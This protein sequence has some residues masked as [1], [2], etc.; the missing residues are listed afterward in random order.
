MSAIGLSLSL[1][2]LLAGMM[3]ADAGYGER[4][5]ATALPLRDVLLS[6][7]FVS[8][9]MLVDPGLFLDEPVTIPRDSCGAPPRE[10]RRDRRHGDADALPAARR[11]ACGREPRT[12]RRIRVRHP[13]PG[14]RPR[15]DQLRRGAAR[16]HRRRRVDGGL[17]C[18]DGAC[19]ATAGRRSRSAAARAA[20]ENAIHRRSSARRPLDARSCRAGGLRRGR[21]PAQPRSGGGPGPSH[22][23]GTQR[24]AREERACVGGAGLLRRRVEPGDS[25]LCRDRALARPRSADQ[26]PGC[27]AARRRRR[28]RPTT[29]A[30]R[31]HSRAL[32]L[33]RPIARRSCGS[34]PISSCTRSWSRV[35]RWQRASSITSAPSTRTYGRLW[36]TCSGR[37]AATWVAGLSRSSPRRRSERRVPETDHWTPTRDRPPPPDGGW[38]GRPRQAGPPPQVSLRSDPTPQR[39][40]AAGAVCAPATPAASARGASIRRAGPASRL[41][42]RSTRAAPGVTA[43][44]M[45][46]ARRRRVMAWAPRGEPQAARSRGPVPP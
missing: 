3:L 16:R 15:V 22:R 23:S 29:R 43:S 37:H 10:D 25:E 41:R 14:R 5:V 21:T 39:G 13:G 24:R 27:D 40:A 30:R 9:G 34:V 38:V 7:F 20:H 31:L 1:G 33:R 12:V 44:R 28:R 18:R 45:P 36:T 26:R 4:A 2:A 11:L 6:I 42:P 19:T 46:P 35:S 32:T 17:A 8:L